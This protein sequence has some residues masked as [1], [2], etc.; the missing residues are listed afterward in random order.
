MTP[1][2]IEA[3]LERLEPLRQ[4]L[5]AR[6]MVFQAALKEQAA[7]MLG[8]P[9]DAFYGYSYADWTKVARR[10]GIGAYQ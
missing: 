4:A 3:E 7:A 1:E 10:L 6:S 8:L 5:M 9:P 2:Q